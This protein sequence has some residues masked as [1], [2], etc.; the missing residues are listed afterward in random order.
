MEWAIPIFLF[1]GFAI[2]ILLKNAGAKREFSYK[3]KKVLFSPAERSFYGV[4]TQ[5]S[6]GN[7][8]VFGK[9][10]IADILEPSKVLNRSEWQIAFNKISSK[11]F[12]YV[13][14]N[15][16]ELAVE[17]V[18]ELDDKS[19]KGKK[20]VIRDEFIQRAC[21]SA[22]LKLHRFKA[23]SSYNISEVREILFPPAIQQTMVAEKKPSPPEENKE[24]KQLCPKCSSELISRVSNRG[25]YKG[26]EFL[27]CSNFPKCRYI[28]K[29]NT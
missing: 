13:I 18:I 29:S 2:V 16:D 11:H 14:C 22:G 19:H 23:S 10:R 1:I 20:Q 8:V 5:A 12:D 7:A 24:Q 21:E 9:V 26:E 15:S 27:A 3:T 6:S 28:L 4:L 17:S 25:K